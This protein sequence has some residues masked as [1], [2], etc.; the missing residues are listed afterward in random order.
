MAESE[1]DESSDVV[2]DTETTDDA[3]VEDALDLLFTGRVDEV[4]PPEEAGEFHDFI[5][6]EAL[7]R[8][9][10]AGRRRFAVRLRLAI[11]RF[12]FLGLMRAVLSP[13][14]EP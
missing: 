2:T 3:G 4:I 9:R 11:E 10:F 14:T 6:E 1:T 5:R 8:R 13:E 7:R 12:L